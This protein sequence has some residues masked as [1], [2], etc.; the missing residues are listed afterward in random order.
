MHDDG[1]T[2]NG[3]TDTTIRTFTLT[4]L[5]INDAPVVGGDGAVTMPE[6]AGAQ[7]AAWATLSP[8][9]TNE[10]DQSLSVTTANDNA[11]LFASQPSVSAAGV[12]SFRTAPNR[13]GSAQ[14]TVTVHDDGGTTHGGTDTTRAPSPSPS[15]RSTTHPS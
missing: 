9:P 11:A 1:G 3:G 7:S 5:P 4:V 15:N 6:D 14:V 13:S 10:A 2:T 8:G 12:L